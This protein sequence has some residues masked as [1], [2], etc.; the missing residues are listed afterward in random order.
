[1]GGVGVWVVFFLFLFLLFF[2]PFQTK[3]YLLLLLLPFS[4]PLLS[5]PF[6]SSPLPSPSFFLAHREE[7]KWIKPNL[8]EC[9]QQIY[10]KGQEHERRDIQEEKNINFRIY[11]GKGREGLLV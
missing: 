1:M 10:Y 5:P 9:N 3:K 6:P 8:R 4:L 7:I 11:F 2:L